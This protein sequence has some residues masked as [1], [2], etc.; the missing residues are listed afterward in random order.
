MY[1]IEEGSQTVEEGDELL[2][3]ALGAQG[4]GDGRETSNG[5]EAEDDIVVLCD[6]SVMYRVVFLTTMSA[7][8]LESHTFSSSMSTAMG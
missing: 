7:L 8:E 3:S 6:T 5:I 4:Q 2:S 1:V